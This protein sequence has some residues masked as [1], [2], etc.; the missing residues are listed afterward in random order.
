MTIEI[1]EGAILITVN[2]RSRLFEDPLITLKTAQEAQQIDF[3]GQDFGSVQL[4]WVKLY[5]G[6]G[7][8]TGRQ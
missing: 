7:P 1:T 6:M 8:R 3:K 2:E 4:D 5:E